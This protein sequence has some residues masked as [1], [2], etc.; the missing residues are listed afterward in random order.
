M[1]TVTPCTSPARRL[2]LEQEASSSSPSNPTIPQEHLHPKTSPPTNRAIHILSS[3]MK[4]VLSSAAE[5]E[6]RALFHNVKDADALRLTLENMGHTQPSTPITTNNKC[7]SGIANKT[8]KQRRSK[9]IDMWYYWV[10]DRIKQGHFHVFWCPGTENWADYIT[11]HYPHIHHRCVRSQY[12]L[13]PTLK[14][15]SFHVRT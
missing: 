11:K 3:T 2:V 6:L 7:A 15:M 10:H 4:N 14:Q 13:D 9:A 1:C 8:V 5:A 12:L